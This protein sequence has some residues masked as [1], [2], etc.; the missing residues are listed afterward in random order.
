MKITPLEIRQKTFEK[1]FRGFEKDE[2]NAYLQSLSMEWERML[3]ENREL[4]LKIESLETESSK[5]RELES[6]LFKTLKT[7]EDTGATLIEQTKKETDLKLKETSLQADSILSDARN[8]AKNLIENAD[9][10]KKQILDEMV[11]KVKAMEV[12][13][14]QM[15]DLKEKVV[16][17]IK[18]Y[19]NEL[20][21]RIEKLEKKSEDL[22]IQD[23]VSEAKQIYNSSVI[24]L[25][26]FHYQGASTGES[27]IIEEKKKEKPDTQAKLAGEEK[28]VKEVITN[29]SEITT[30]VEIKK[31]T[32]IITEEKIGKEE[33]E[34]G[35]H[36]KII[37]NNGQNISK[38]DQEEELGLKNDIEKQSEIGFEDKK[39][40]NK[41]ASKSFFDDID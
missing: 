7:A 6:S 34:E 10:K 36:G 37:E 30:E 23:I 24:E 35:N 33:M 38:E 25:L 31:E 32:E 1:V 27:T 12:L 13:F 15:V 20:T 11:N 19:S 41:P 26:D 16:G 18:M 22:H 14:D 29:V 21:G 8:K 3:D 2:V 28:E 40:E 4:H 39:K 9:A 17:Q 5:L